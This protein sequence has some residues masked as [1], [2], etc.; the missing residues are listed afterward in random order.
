MKRHSLGLIETWGFLPAVEAVDA[1]MKSA[2]VIFAGYEITRTALVTVKFMGD[3]AAVSTAVRAGMAAAEKV[4]KVIATHVIPRPDLQLNI[5]PPKPISPLKKTKE[6]PAIT[7]ESKSETQAAGA[8]AV[9]KA[10][11]PAGSLP[12][13]TQKEEK[14]KETPEEESLPPKKV[15]KA[16][17]AKPRPV[18]KKA[19]KPAKPKPP[20]EKSRKKRSAPEKKSS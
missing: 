6:T 3:V 7:K 8:G 4:G 14:K 13:T 10:K 16:K 11:R 5:T 9:K 2:N 15:E 1:G 12:E 18:K 17:K 19:K 20:S